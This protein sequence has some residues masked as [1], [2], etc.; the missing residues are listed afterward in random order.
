MRELRAPTFKRELLQAVIDLRKI[1]TRRVMNPQPP[2]DYRPCTCDKGTCHLYPPEADPGKVLTVKAPHGLPGD[3]WALKEPL[4]RCK[5]GGIAL[6]ADGIPVIDR[7]KSRMVPWLWQV[8]VLT[9]MFMP[10]WA[11]RD[12]VDVTGLRVER[13]QDITEAD[14]IAEGIMPDQEYW[15]NAG[16]EDLFDCP[17]CRGFQVYPTGTM[18]G[19]TEAECEYCDTAIKRFGILWDSISAK[20]KPV[21]RQ[22]CQ[23]LKEGPGIATARLLHHYVNFPWED[24]RETR[25]HRGKP[26][27]VIGNAFVWVYDFSGYVRDPGRPMP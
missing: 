16:E 22:G 23:G 25:E 14:A 5:E 15:D 13:L 4:H 6:Y 7:R 2:L 20:P 21:Y 10:K 3:V 18:S 26:W 8:N 12:Y 1:Q 19:A 9:S 11:A 17:V 24:I 27:Y